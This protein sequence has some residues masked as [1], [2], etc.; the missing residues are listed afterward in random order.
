MIELLHLSDTHIVEPGMHPELAYEHRTCILTGDVTDNGTREEYDAAARVLSP[1][2]ITGL[3]MCP[4]NHDQGYL[5]NLW[6]P[7]CEERWWE[8]AS[9]MQN[10]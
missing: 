5:G 10:C 3:Y 2:V 9:L 8:F 4:G 6:T 1:L 7:S